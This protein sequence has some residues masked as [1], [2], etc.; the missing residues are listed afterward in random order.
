VQQRYFYSVASS[1]QSIMQFYQRRLDINSS[2]IYTKSIYLFKERIN[3]TVMAKVFQN[4]RS[5]AIRIPK[6][7]RVNTD[8]VYIDK[9]GDT[10]ILKPKNSNKWD[11]FFKALESVDTHDFMT[12]RKQLPIQERE[13][14]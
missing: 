14:F 8:E 5:Q 10:L 7:F 12:D 2:L 9:V 13:I 6:E 4:G 1:H 3:M 11:A